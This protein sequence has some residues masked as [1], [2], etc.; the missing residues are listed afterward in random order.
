MKHSTG[1]PTK[2]Q[3]R[4]FEALQVLGCIACRKRGYKHYPAEIHHLNLGG[5]AGQKRRGHDFTI[6]LCAWHHRGDSGMF[7]V[8]SN[9]ERFG[10]S[11]AK[12]S[13]AFRIEFG[14]DDELL[15]EVNALIG[16]A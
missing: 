1:T 4:R 15:S 14:T 16:E 8:S 13:K 9:L 3:V 11:L 2:A 7:K 12:S 6:P 5:K 10:P